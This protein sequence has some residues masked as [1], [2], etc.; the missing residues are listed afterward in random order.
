MTFI[1]PCHLFFFWIFFLYKFVTFL[2]QGLVRISSAQVRK[3]ELANFIE[4]SRTQLNQAYTHEGF[5]GAV[6]LVDEKT[7]KSIMYCTYANHNF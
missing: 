5:R 1:F 6:L 4:F 7:S 3:G 2:T